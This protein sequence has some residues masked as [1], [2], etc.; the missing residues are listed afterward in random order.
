MTGKKNDKIY[1]AK[2]DLVKRKYGL[3]FSKMVKASYEDF[4]Y[5]ARNLDENGFKECKKLRSSEKNRIAA[6]MKR[7]RDSTD[8]TER[9][10]KYN[11]A[12]QKY[13][14][15]ELQEADVEISLYE[16]VQKLK[17]EYYKVLAMYNLDPA[18]NTIVRLPN[19]TLLVVKKGEMDEEPPNSVLRYEYWKTNN[20]AERNWEDWY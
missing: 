2:S 4:Q 5:M 10:M 7:S 12:K 6:A 8:L 17:E 9:E 15:L 3:N 16:N 18:T 20:N 19:Q 1:A 13:A 14:K 11:I